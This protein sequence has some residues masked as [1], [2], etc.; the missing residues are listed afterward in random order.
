MLIKLFE[1][2]ASMAGGL[3]SPDASFSVFALSGGTQYIPSTDSFYVAGATHHYRA[4]RDGTMVR[5]GANLGGGSL[6]FYDWNA[7]LPFY[8]NLFTPATRMRFDPITWQPRPA[9]SPVLAY[10]IVAA[11]NYQKGNILKDGLLWYRLNATQ[12]RA[13]DATTGSTVTTLTTTGTASAYAIEYF[14]F[15][16][17]SL[18]IA[19]QWYNSFYNLGVVRVHD[20]A[21]DTTLYETRID[22]AWRGAL[23]HVNNT[24]WSINKSTN[25]AQLWSLQPAPSAFSPFTVGSNRKR[26]R[27]DA[28]TTTLVGA[29]GELIKNWPVGWT[30]DTAEGHLEHLYTETDEDGVTTNKYCGPGADDYAG[31]TQIITAWTG[32]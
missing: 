2:A 32:Y 1:S 26:Y 24:I 22:S 6:Y 12:V 4:Y 20:V 19:V 27:E 13:L 31:G 25:N 30:L 3:K 8:I 23:D 5:I 14:G 17:D 28:I 16:R 21:T 10:D 11:T 18:M 9:T 15:T 29:H 7:G